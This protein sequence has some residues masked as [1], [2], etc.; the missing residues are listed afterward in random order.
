MCLCITCIFKKQ[1]SFIHSVTIKIDFVFENF[2]FLLNDLKFL[3]SYFSCLKHNV[4]I[5]F[6][7]KTFKSDILEGIIYL[8]RLKNLF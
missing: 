6:S 5:G 4:S 8:I 3:L 7:T 2:L 1:F